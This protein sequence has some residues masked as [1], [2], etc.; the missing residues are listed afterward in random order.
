MSTTEN[1]E[2][3]TD[4]EDQAPVINPMGPTFGKYALLVD[5]MQDDKA[6]ELKLCSLARP[7][8]RAFHYAWGSFFIANFVSFIWVQCNGP[9]C[10]HGYLLPYLQ[11]VLLLFCMIL[12]FLSLGF[13]LILNLIS[14]LLLL[15]LN[16]GSEL[17]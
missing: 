7:H 16:R 12:Y 2:P 3:V 6:T 11:V 15:N 17:C 10:M 13:L 4:V 8:M 9:Y 5:K 14:L 1:P